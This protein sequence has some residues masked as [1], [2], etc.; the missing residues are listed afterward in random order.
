MDASI[1]YEPPHL[2]GVE[3]LVVAGKIKKY[4]RRAERERSE[5]IAGR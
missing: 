2:S 4:E 1:R 5:W 3:P